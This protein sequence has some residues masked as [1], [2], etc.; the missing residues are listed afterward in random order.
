MIE[1]LFSPKQ[2]A[3][4][5]GVSESSLKRWCDR[6]LIDTRRT[7]GGH[8]RISL[9]GVCRFLREHDQEL[10]QPEL[11]GL[12]ATIGRGRR[13]LVRAQIACSLA[14][15]GEMRRPVARSR[16]ISTWPAYSVSQLCDHLLAEAMHRVGEDWQC[17]EIEV[18]QERLGCEIFDRVL[19]D[20]RQVIPAAGARC[21]GGDRGRSAGRSVH[22]GQSHGGGRA[23]CGRMAGDIAGW[24]LALRYADPGSSSRKPRL[25]WLSVSAVDCEQRFLEQYERFYREVSEVTAV[26]V[27]GQGLTKPFRQQMQFCGHC[28]NLEELREFARNL[29]NSN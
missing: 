7:G 9:S 12:P 2:V 13:C 23:A 21:G 19:N 8:R 3:R 22:A 29:W 26:V 17:G 11:L 1:K 25:F 18:F 6:G 16:W 24:L 15:C 14:S 27:G 28:E 4:A 20:F 10:M 5:L